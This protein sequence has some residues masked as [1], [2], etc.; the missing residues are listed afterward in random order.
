MVKLELE[1]E[2]EKK[3]ELKKRQEASLREPVKIES[4]YGRYQRLLVGNN[5]LESQAAR[6]V[7]TETQGVELILLL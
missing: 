1:E 4:F 3:K 2:E 6:D 5:I 7:K